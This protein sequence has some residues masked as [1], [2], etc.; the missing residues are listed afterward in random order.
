MKAVKP[1]VEGEQLRAGTTEGDIAERRPGLRQPRR[2]P[3]GRVRQATQA[4]L[5]AGSFSLDARSW[6]ATATA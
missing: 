6:Y 1:E 5:P 4:Q 3:E 2:G